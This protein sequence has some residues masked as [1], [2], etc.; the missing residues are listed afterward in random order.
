[1]YFIAIFVVNAVCQ[2]DL[3]WQLSCIDITKNNWCPS[4][5]LRYTTS[6]KNMIVVTWSLTPILLWSCFLIPDMG[7]KTEL[8]LV[9]ESA[10]VFHHLVPVTSTQ[11]GKTYYFIWIVSGAY[12]K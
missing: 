3:L 8:R 1:M 9:L 4:L 7:S 11:M 2:L 5:L 12:L 10:Y 6:K